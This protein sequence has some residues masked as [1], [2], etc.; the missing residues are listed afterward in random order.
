[1]TVP[2]ITHDVRGH[3]DKSAVLRCQLRTENQHRDWYI[4]TWHKVQPDG[5]QLPLVFL[6][7]NRKTP[8]WSAEIPFDLRSRIQPIIT[9]ERGRVEF[10][11]KISNL[12]CADETEY[13]IQPII[14]VERGRV[15][16]NV[17]ISNLTCADEAEYR[18]QTPKISNSFPPKKR[19]SNS[20]VECKA[21]VG[22]PPQTLIWYIKRPGRKYFSMIDKQRDLIEETDGCH[23]MSTRSVDVTSRGYPRG[24]RFRCG[25]PG[26]IEKPGMY[27]EYVLDFNV[28]GLHMEEVREKPKLAAVCKNAECRKQARPSEDLSEGHP[29]SCSRLTST[30]EPSVLILAVWLF[31]CLGRRFVTTP[32]CFCNV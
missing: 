6:R 7:V 8:E 22:L 10:N 2:L 3:V 14:T 27:E 23:F 31:H 16:F 9:V 25:Y 11:V 28:E 26:Y 12:T 17:K 29:D 32:M 20:I 4:L 15:E 21:D 1:M 24:T 30:L 18:P 19:G 13:R 5:K